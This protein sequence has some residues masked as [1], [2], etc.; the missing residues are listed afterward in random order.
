[1]SD[2]LI[3]NCSILE[4][5]ASISSGKNILISNG[6]IKTIAVQPIDIPS[7][8]VF[9]GL[10]F[11]ATPSFINAHFHLGET[12]FRGF[13]PLD[14]LDNYIRFTSRKLRY[15]TESDYETV[16]QKSL[17]EAIKSGTSAIMGARGWSA[18]KKS[19]IRGV[20]GYPLMNS[21]KLTE[22]REGFDDKLKEQIAKDS[23]K[24]K[25]CVWI[26]SVGSISREEWIKVAQIIK[27]NNLFLTLHVA[28]TKEQVVD[29]KTKVGCSEI[30]FLDRLNLLNDKL[31]IVHGAFL[32]DSELKLIAKYNTNVAVCP[33]S[34]YSL[35]QK[36]PDI[37]KMVDYGINVSLATDGLA[38]G[39][40]AS[41]LDVAS[42]ASANYN[43]P[44]S[45]AFKMITSNPAKTMGLNSFGDL[46]EGSIADICLIKNK[47]HCLDSLMREKP[48]HLIV[49]GRF[50]MKNKRINSLP[51]DIIEKEFKAVIQKN[52]EELVFQKP[53]TSD[54]GPG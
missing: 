7:A 13:A 49:D 45:V 44:N 15:F 10:G 53:T 5:D 6:K 26:H 8:G 29:S 25:T 51:E 18:V 46:K 43:L 9:D 17:L 47:G 22:F 24:I 20:L 36:L 41:L 40:T 1:M 16:C 4:P 14:T 33:L 37:S 50:V 21:S 42:F 3:Q 31:N 27:D 30:E 12:L 39:G 23:D 35:N 52:I 28:E 38:T 11:V 32:T 54:G 48:S 2:F 19:G 34:S